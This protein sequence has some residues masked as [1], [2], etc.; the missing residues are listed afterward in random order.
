MSLVISIL[1][2]LFIFYLRYIPISIFWKLYSF[3]SLEKGIIENKSF[4]SLFNRRLIEGLLVFFSYSIAFIVV[5]TLVIAISNYFFRDNTKSV[6]APMILFSS[7]DYLK[8]LKE[9]KYFSILFSFLL[10][11]WFCF[12][13]RIFLWR[14]T[15][16]SIRFFAILLI[17]IGGIDVYNDYNSHI[18]PDVFDF[19]FPESGSA[20]FWGG[21]VLLNTTFFLLDFLM[22]TSRSLGWKDRL[23]KSFVMS[24]TTR[25]FVVSRSLLHPYFFL[26]PHGR[27]LVKTNN[28]PTNKLSLLLEKAFVKG[29][30][31]IPDE[32]LEK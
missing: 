22:P 11:D 32:W 7:H 17:V 4:A 20:F 25:E 21:I 23:E 30:D 16:L 15:V 29:K 27:L 5:S 10:S 31:W 8:I 3:F 9:R 2:L 24:P 19:L 6:L 1:F 18:N 26:S 12:K 13:K 14:S 28:T